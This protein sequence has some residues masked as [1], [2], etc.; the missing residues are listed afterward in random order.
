M[1][2]VCDMHWPEKKRQSSAR[3]ES[4]IVDRSFLSL[5]FGLDYSLILPVKSVTTFLNSSHSSTVLLAQCLKVIKITSFFEFFCWTI[6]IFCSFKYSF[7]YLNLRAKN[8][9]NCQI[10]L[11]EGFS[12][13]VDFVRGFFFFSLEKRF[14]PF[15]HLDSYRWHVFSSSALHDDMKLHETLSFSYM[16]P[17]FSLCV[18][19]SKKEKSIFFDKRR[20]L[21]FK[22]WKSS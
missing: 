12:N 11:F 5:A 10:I 16:E 20:L 14:F 8:G 18:L 9:L 4:E 1:R 6:N 13:N 17:R 3:R 7:K 22:Q 15:S 2:R 19:H 21:L